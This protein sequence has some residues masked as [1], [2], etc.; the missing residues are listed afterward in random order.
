MYFDPHT[1]KTTTDDDILAVLAA[2]SCIV[3]S[4]AALLN[5]CYT[6]VE[7]S[8]SSKRKRRDWISMAC[9]IS[10]CVIVRVASGI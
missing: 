3:V 10:S 1:C 6:A 8:R 5:L 2:Y 4:I 9:T 7:I